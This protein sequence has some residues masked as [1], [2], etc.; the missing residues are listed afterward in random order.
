V[1]KKKSL[2]LMIG[3]PSEN[4]SVFWLNCGTSVSP[5]IALSPGVRESKAAFWMTS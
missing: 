1:P 4:P 5:L 3:P 2:F